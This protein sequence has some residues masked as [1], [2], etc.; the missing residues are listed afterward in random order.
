VR[1][2]EVE[3]RPRFATICRTADRCGANR[4]VT[5]KR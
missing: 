1:L 2:F 3:I 4:G 5:S